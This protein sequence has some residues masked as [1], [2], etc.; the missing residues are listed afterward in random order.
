[1][2]VGVTSLP[3]AL[4]NTRLVLTFSGFTEVSPPHFLLG[5]APVCSHFDCSSFYFSTFGDDI[6]KFVGCCWRNR[7]V[8]QRSRL[9]AESATV[10][11]EKLG[12]GPS[13]EE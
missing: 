3:V 13:D 12:R 6:L 7:S 9:R 1:M 11:G 10:T 8:T 5:A 4:K 2:R